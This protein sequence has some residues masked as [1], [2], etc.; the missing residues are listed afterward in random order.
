MQ[1]EKVE[2]SSGFR[3]RDAEFGRRAARHQNEKTGRDRE[4]E[5]KLW[6]VFSVLTAAERLLQEQ[7]AISVE[8]QVLPLPLSLPQRRLQ[9]TVGV[10]L[11]RAEGQEGDEDE[12]RLSG[13]GGEEDHAF[14]RGRRQDRGVV[15]GTGTGGS[16]GQRQ[17]T[18][19][20][21]RGLLRHRARVEVLPGA[22]RRLQKGLA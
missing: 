9:A 15:Q 11:G 12:D 17:S 6:A 2:L 5:E 4:M 7:S 13:A 22:A 19:D 20:R 21:V 8:N 14:V 1:Q 10:A 18:E 3:F 16:Q